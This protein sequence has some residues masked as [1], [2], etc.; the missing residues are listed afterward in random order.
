MTNLG[1]FAVLRGRA[2]AH[3][4]ST[5]GAALARRRPGLV[6]ALGVALLGLV[7]TPPTAVFVAKVLTIAVTWE[8]GLAWLAVLVAANT[9]L[10]LAYYL[11][12]LAACLSAPREQDEADVADPPGRLTAARL[13]YG[14]AVAA[15][16]LGLVAGPVLALAG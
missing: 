4:A 15:V 12:W 16:A 9:V 8:A 13:A 11:R 5:T 7:G 2:R 3:R 14:C 6:A 1:C 10:S